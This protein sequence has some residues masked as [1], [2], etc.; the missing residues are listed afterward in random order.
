M[1]FA[2]VV[3]ALFAVLMLVGGVAGWRAARSKP[4]LIAGTTSAVVLAGAFVISLNEPVPG[5]WLGAITSLALFVVFALRWL[6]TG[7][8]MPSGMLMLSSVLVLLVVT[9]AALEAQGKL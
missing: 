7:K 2:Q 4:S 8:F 5:Y 1:D 3:L 6:K 9:H